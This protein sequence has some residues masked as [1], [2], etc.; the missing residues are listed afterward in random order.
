MKQNEIKMPESQKSKLQ[1]EKYAVDNF[2]IYEE[3]KLKDE[4]LNKLVN[5]PLLNAP[6]LEKTVTEIMNTVREKGDQAILDFSQKFHGFAPENLWVTASEI[7]NAKFQIDP[8]LKKAIFIAKKNI[9][10]FHKAQFEKTKKI[11]TMPGVI[12]WRKSVPI[13]KIGLYIPGGSAPLFS[14][15]LM[16]GIPATLAG[17]KDIIVASPANK[18]GQ[19]DQ[20]ILFVADLLGIKKIFKGGGAQAIAALAYGTQTVDKVDKIFGPGNQYVTCAKRLVN[21]DGVDI[22]ML[23]GPSELAVFADQTSNPAFVAADL[24]SQAEHGIDSHLLLASNNNSVCKKIFKEIQK[25]I[26]VLERKEI[27][28]RCI[29]NMTTIVFSDTSVAFNFINQYAPEHLIIATDRALEYSE[30]VIN[31]GSVFIGHYSPESVGDYASGTNHSLPTYGMAKT[32][33]GVSVDSFVKKIT[34]QEL[35]ENGLKNIGKVVEILAAAE[36]LQAHKNAVSIRLK[37]IAN[38]NI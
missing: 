2:K 14:T 6:E 33:S 29:E 28:L 23:A 18:T 8:Q 5:R 27:A 17:C 24:L 31:A 12:C 20:V 37:N 25:Q 38:E 7:E 1:N 10:K 21:A 22:D 3:L 32:F 9:E 19:V 35:N 26:S 36:G 15:L 4:E 16:L 11:E 34:Y 30:W 13:Q